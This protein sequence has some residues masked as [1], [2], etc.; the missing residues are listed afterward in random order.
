MSEKNANGKFKIHW[1]TREHTIVGNAL[2]YNHHNKMMRK[3]AE[4]FFEFDDSSPIA[5]HIVPANLYVPVEGKFNILFTMWEGL[6]I[7]PAY[8]RGIE[9]ADALITPCRFCKDLF[10][11]YAKGP[12][13]V[14][15][16][17]VEPEKFPFFQRSKTDGKRFR[18]LWV[19]AP[20]PRK[21]YPLV[22]E[23]IK[24][25]EQMPNVEIYLKTTVPKIGKLKSILQIFKH[26]KQ[27]INFEHTKGGKKVGWDFIWRTLQRLPRPSLAGKVRV[28]GKH[29]NIFFDTRLLP[30][31]ELLAL[32]NSAHC[33]VLPSMGEGWGL[34]L[35][36]AMATGAPCVASCNTGTADFFDASV[37]YPIKHE[38]VETAFRDYDFTGRIYMPD[39]QDFVQKMLDVF[40]NYDEAL[41]RGK[42]AHRKIHDIFTWRNSAKRL[43]EIVRKVVPNDSHSVGVQKIS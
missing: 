24:I 37:G 29:K 8:Y 9:S 42:R 10:Q 41:R 26:W 35:C 7:P 5:L 20:N 33:F 38:V 32:Y 27:I 1:V 17:G 18:Y 23:S 21:G 13:E 2:G 11:K 43:Y 6:D 31:D 3:Y 25:I 16:E 4:E 15:W 12:V 30:F 14:C 34:T 19:G 39:T 40:G 28:M 36:E 22:L